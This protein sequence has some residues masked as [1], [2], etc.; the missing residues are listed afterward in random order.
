MS[1]GKTP[2]PDDPFEYYLNYREKVGKSRST[3][4]NDEAAIDL[5]QEFLQ[6]QKVAP[7]DVTPEI[8][9]RFLNWLEYEEGYAERTTVEHGEKVHGFYQYYST[10][11]FYDA[12]PMGVALD[13]DNRSRN[14]TKRVP[15]VTVSQMREII[16]NISHPLNLVI[17]LILAKTGIRRGEL[18]NIDLRD[19][20]ID[21]GRLDDI[22]PEPRGEIKHNPDSLYIPHKIRE[23]QEYNGEVREKGNKRERGTTIPI[24]DELKQVL[25][26]WLAIRPPANSPAQPL[27]TTPEAQ[28]TGQEFGDRIRYDNVYVRVR[29]VAEREGLWHSPGRSGDQSTANINVHFFRHF[30]TT[31]MRDRADDALVKFI[32]GDVG[33]DV[34][35]EYTH[36]WGNKVEQEYKESI[37][38]LIR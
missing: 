14:K 11:G 30:F 21:D 6:E 34:M 16:A 3:I 23:N 24:D 12:N 27:L 10:R 25:I 20:N 8:C 26:Y 7:E 36:Q 1:V 5:F 37:Y 31:H 9:T 29:E 28:G 13:E 38:K 2:E 17:I 18:Y 19:L 32:R 4:L 35:D 22:L 15:E 33:D